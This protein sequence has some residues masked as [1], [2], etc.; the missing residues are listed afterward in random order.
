MK[1]IKDKQTIEE[2][3]LWAN[4]Q[5]KTARMALA[6]Y[7]EENGEPAIAIAIRYLLK[8]NKWVVKESHYW[9]LHIKNYIINS[10]LGRNESTSIKNVLRNH[11]KKILKVKRDLENL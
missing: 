5:D 4:I 7:Y 6:D 3:A 1:M 11:G 8:L 2:R 9:Y 10:P